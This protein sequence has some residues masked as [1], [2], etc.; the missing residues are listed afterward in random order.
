MFAVKYKIEYLYCHIFTMIIL[1]HFLS[2]CQKLMMKE[3]EKLATFCVFFIYHFLIYSNLQRN[4]ILGINSQSSLSYYIIEWKGG[5]GGRLAEPI[6]KFYVHLP[7]KGGSEC[8]RNTCYVLICY[9]LD[10]WYGEIKKYKNEWYIYPLIVVVVIVV[11][12]V[13]VVGFFNSKL[14]YVSLLWT[15]RN[16]PHLMNS[17]IV[18]IVYLRCSYVY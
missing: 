17:Q 16:N 15:D 2:K 12:V 3:F 14:S 13:V 4:H 10:L 11:V 6:Q 1:V 18:F 9:D 8:C 5:G 7:R